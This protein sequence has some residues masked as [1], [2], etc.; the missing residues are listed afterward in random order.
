[1]QISLVRM[2]LASPFLINIGFI[3]CKESTAKEYKYV[4]KT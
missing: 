2:I 4:K 3:G 1:M